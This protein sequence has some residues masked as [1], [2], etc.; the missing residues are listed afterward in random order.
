[1]VMVNLM[2]YCAHNALRERQPGF[3]RY[4]YA[5]ATI[6]AFCAVACGEEPTEP[7]DPPN[8]APVATA[9]IPS[10]TVQAGESLLLD[11][12]A[13]FN[14]PDGDNLSFAA[15]SSDTTVAN[16]SVSGSTVTVMALARGTASVTATATDPDGLT[17]S[18][19]FSVTVPNRPP[20]VSDSIGARE[21]PVGDSL[22]VDLSAYFND[23]DGD[24]LNFAAAS[25]DTTVAN[26]SVSGSTVTV[27]VLARGTASVTA[28]ATDPDGLTASQTF[29]VTVP[30]RPPLVSD[31]IG[32]R[33]LPVGDSLLVDLS[34]YFND[35]DGDNLSFAAASSDTTVAAP[36]VSGSTVTVM[37]LARGTASVTATAT[38]PDGLTASQSF[39]VT[40]P[41]RPPLVS[42]SIGARELPVGDSLLV[43][44]SAYFNDPDGD[45]LSFAAASSDTTVAAP[46]VSGSTV[47]V[48]ALARGTASVTAT[49]T[50]PDGLTASQSFSVTVPNRPPLVSDS[51]GA[52][53]LPVGDSLLVDLSAYFNDPDGDNL[54]FAA[55][56]SDTTVANTSVSGSTVTVMAL[57]RGTAS[58]TATATDPDGLTA[59]QSFSVTVPNRPPLVSDS[60]LARELPAGD[61]LLVDLSAYFND[62]DGDS[63]SF[64]AAS[65]DTTVAAPS[66]SGSTVTVM[67]L[68][69]GTASVTA[70]ATDPDGLTASQSFSV[71]VPNRPPLVSDSI[72]ARELPAGDS[73]LVDLSAYFNDPDGDSLSFAAASSDTTVAA[74]SVSGSTVTVMALARGTASV[75]AT[76]TDPDGL[77]ASQSFSVTVPNRPPLVSDSIGA[78]E[79][80]VGDSLLV[81]LSAYFNDPDGDNLSFAAASSDTTVANT[82]VSGSTVTVMALATGSAT[83]AVTAFD[84]TGLS[85]SQHFAVT[86]VA[87]TIETVVVTPDSVRLTSVSA[88]IRLTAEAFD[89]FGRIVNGS[90]FTWSSGD[91]SVAIVN[92]EGLV[93]ATGNG[94][95]V[96]TVAAGPASDSVVVRVTPLVHAVTV[97]PA[98]ATLVPG[99]SVRLTASPVDRHG[100]PVAGAEVLWATSDRLAVEV[101]GSEGAGTAVARGI[102]QGSATITASSGYARGTLRVTVS[103][104]PDRA[105]LLSL[106]EATGGPDW[107]NSANWGTDA[108][109][110]DWYGVQADVEGRVTELALPDN[111][112]KGPIPAELGS[113]ARLT[114][115]D[116]SRNGLLGAIP[117]EIG[118]LTRLRVLRLDTNFHLT[119]P[120]PP[121]FGSLA[122]LQDLRLT[123]NRL[124]GPIPPELASLSNLAR[125]E[126]D[127]NE[128]T[129]TIPAQLG[130][131]PELTVLS[132]AH[133][134]LTGP[135]PAELGSLAN[136]QILGLSSNRLTGAVPRELAGAPRLQRL[137]L[138]S[139][140]L[141]GT[142]PR[143]FLGSRMIRFHF[144]N[145][146]GLCAPGTSD[147]VAWL[148]SI[149]EADGS[150]CNAADIAAL[151]SLFEAA[152]GR[153]WTNSDGW[154]SGVVLGDWYGVTA[155]SVGR[156]LALDLGG[157]GL[158]GP[159]PA[160]L[161]RLAGMTELRIDDNALVGP[162]PVDLV[163]LQLRAFHYSD[164]ELCTQANA[165]F[166][167]WLDGIASH[168]GTDVEC[169][170]LSDRDILVA[171]Y[172]ATGGPG[173]T[174]SDN[175]LSGEPLDTWE[176]VRLDDDGRVSRLLVGLNNLAG[177]IPP[178]LGQL[179]NLTMLFLAYNH[180]TGPIPPELGAATELRFLYLDHNDL[181]GPIPPELSDLSDLAVL[182]LGYNRLTGPVPPELGSLD[183]LVWLR[184]ND[185]QLTGTIPPE[186]G[187]LERADSLDLSGNA[188]TGPIPR[189]LGQLTNLESLFLDRNNLTG[190]IPPEIGRLGRLRRLS[191]SRNNLAGRL[192]TDIGNLTELTQLS[193]YNNMRLSGALPGNLTSLRR[194]REFQAGGTGLC[195]LFEP[196]FL[197][198]LRE[199]PVSRVRLCGSAES[200]AYL[201]QAAQSLDFPV[202]LI[203]GEEALLRVFVTAGHA[204]TAGIPPVRATFFS[205]DSE[206]F[207]ANIPGQSSAIPTEV[208][209]SSLW[210]SA[211]VTIPGHVLEP[212]LE[213]VIDVDPDGTLDPSLGVKRR[214]PETGR[215]RQDVRAMPTMELTLIPFLWTGDSD[216]AIVDFVEAMETDHETR[217]W[218]IHTLLPVGDLVVT[219]HEPVWS[220]SN[221]GFDM[222][223]QTE[224][225]RVME[226]GSGYYMGMSKRYFGLGGVARLRGKSSWSVA[227]PVVMAH[228]LGHNMSLRHAPC[229]GAG[230]PDPGFPEPD[231]TVGVWGYDFRENG[232]LVSASTPDFMSYCDPDWTSGYHFA[233]ALGYRLESDTETRTAASAEPVQSL[234]LWGGVDTDGYPVLEPSFVVTVPPVLPSEPGDHRLEGRTAGGDLLFALDFDMA[235][236]EDGDGS[237][238]FAF[239]L[240]VQRGWADGLASVTLSGP[241]GVATLNGEQD[242]TVA[243][244]RD[245]RSGRIRGFFR[246]PPGTARTQVDEYLA[247]VT[248]AEVEVLVS[249][250]IPSPSDWRR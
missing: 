95:T 126:L 25:S 120:I 121:Q 55:A 137:S 71:T 87:R 42:D 13:Y 81:D 39:S 179:R 11:L 96:I 26:T 78:R 183:D 248:D 166:R 240:P 85:A 219:P 145:N 209:E 62:P 162:L 36:S 150:F 174:N 72:L 79:L 6:L 70:T 224:V 170:P 177:S 58:V 82:S 28:T 189:A 231:G 103:L 225:I 172:H 129:G 211:N 204:T 138:D 236:T 144:G 67:A 75:T 196:D 107:E 136:L 195:A 31:S 74:P 234:L 151:M 152:G 83:I 80:P 199:I 163:N 176:G 205:G 10:A 193:L 32:A 198:W 184:L 243:I 4:R 188:L 246:G 202:P 43:D 94:E 201:T 155:D 133:N 194:L 89:Q 208:I 167:G 12:S 69:R 115:L 125:L 203:A 131:L 227:E 8:R 154:L 156:V 215:L 218:P 114:A 143:V 216:S 109:L 105:V 192:P 84:P 111:N 117:Q 7:P 56:S 17:A 91:S 61:S 9:S 139:N 245:L 181:T 59:S 118:S 132:L 185:N 29:S 113:L 102:G 57:A 23:P 76:A 141:A 50:D 99:E 60:I 24:S 197:Q 157:N 169:G 213:M 38:D 230:G 158:E 233:N 153:G 54:S 52:R 214:I 104:D 93:L 34:A 146:D 16:T 200:T 33:E 47:T 90:D 226:G 147:Y 19:S 68:A 171:F 217:L 128:L 206:T 168:Q 237:T 92:N 110:G 232:R 182:S 165:R 44:L 46:S 88:T 140:R 207:V 108:P 242:R 14:D 20:L 244:L 41:N 159:V 101:R 27:M 73:L 180:L 21:L 127:Y 35:P 142:I 250:G 15:A 160:T 175:W 229:G 116:V 238:G 134:R 65:S 3:T 100:H 106:F 190:P 45:N 149:R 1:M 222:L 77:T 135:I 63:L 30:N 178:E 220:S 112:L 212:G 221:N 122:S 49:A 64:A 86:T 187:R 210:T 53:E 18:Q 40:V 124:T 247:A 249:G 228:E 148:A 119:G 5:V 2:T 191:L 235:E 22:L 48:M 98:A 51:I 173:W 123:F 239:A 241:G 161:T 223:Q 66:V 37:A 186:L 97:T 130:S 164:T